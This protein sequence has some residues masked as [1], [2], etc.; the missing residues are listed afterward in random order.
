MHV[1]HKRKK[2]R[3]RCRLENLCLSSILRK[4]SEYF[5]KINNYYYICYHYYLLLLK[6]K[7]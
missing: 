2:D 4:L 5:G 3:I 1:I 6:I 7:K